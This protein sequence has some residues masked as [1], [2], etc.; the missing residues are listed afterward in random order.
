MLI[1]VAFICLKRNEKSSERGKSKS[2]FRHQM[3]SS[4]GS[5]EGDYAGFLGMRRIFEIIEL[6]NVQ[7]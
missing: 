6:K 3:H 2:L 5:L 4:S 1:V 7:N